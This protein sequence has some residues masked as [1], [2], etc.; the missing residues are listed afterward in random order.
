MSY[1]TFA[2][3][4]SH[5]PSDSRV[6]VDAIRLVVEDFHDRGT[7]A[8]SGKGGQTFS[9]F[10][11]S[12]TDNIPP[13]SAELADAIC[14]LSR[15]HIVHAADATLGVGEEDRG[16][17]ITADIL[18]QYR[19]PRTLARWTPSGAPGEVKVA[20]SNEYLAEGSTDLY[21]NGVRPND[22]IILIDDLISTGGTLV[23]LI[24]AITATGA[25]IL[26]IFTIGEK[27]ENKGRDFIA[28]KTGLK[29]KTLLATDLHDDGRG[30][31]SRVKHVNLGRLDETC[32]AEV[33]QHFPPGFCRTGSGFNI[34]TD[35]LS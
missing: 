30:L 25:D 17:M 32:F 28:Q 11:T 29:V 22:R 16:A 14:L 7:N 33:S 21:L 1:T 27:T 34:L 31:R 23:S 24:Q 13:L 26:E 8:V 5:D 19:L 15:L 35:E 3:H 12:I 9:F 10:P 6:I 20:L 4:P 18:R 2:A